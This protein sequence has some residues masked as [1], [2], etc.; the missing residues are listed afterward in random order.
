MLQRQGGIL[1]KLTQRGI[2]LI[3]LQILFRCLSP[4][5]TLELSRRLNPEQNLTLLQEQCLI[6]CRQLILEGR[7]A[8]KIT[9]ICQTLR[10]LK[11]PILSQLNQVTYR[12]KTHFPVARVACGV[13]L[14]EA[15]TILDTRDMAGVTQGHGW[16]HLQETTMKT[17]S[18]CAC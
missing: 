5:K 9:K 10:F 2:L 6:R 13:Q 12:I 11:C 8:A 4:E 18:C 16:D 7:L 14:S 3:R 17:V 1:Q 15:S